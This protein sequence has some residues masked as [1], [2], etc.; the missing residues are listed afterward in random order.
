[1]AAQT[2]KKHQ[3]AEAV[4]Y[5]ELIRTF[6]KIGVLSFGG[7]A[8][9]IAL[10]HRILVEEKGWLDEKQLP[11]ALNFCMLLPGPEAMQLA[12]YC[13]WLLRGVKGGL[14]AGWLFVL[15]GAA[16]L[17]GG[18]LA[19]AD[20]IAR[21]AVQPAELPLGVVTA[22]IGAPFFFWLLIR[23]KAKGALG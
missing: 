18:L 12:T 4:G 10:M 6:G 1:M 20:L 3:P 2:R 7:P 23:D 5:D 9:Q 14:I 8:G 11:P 21:L 15:P 13:G 16:L 19:F 22:F 17:G